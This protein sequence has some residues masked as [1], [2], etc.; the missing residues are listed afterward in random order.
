MVAEADR[1]V[2]S[3]EETRGVE[4]GYRL[5]EIYRETGIDING[6]G[7]LPVI[8]KLPKQRRCT[9]WIWLSRGS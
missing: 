9:R 6:R 5:L 4:T 8:L 3:T 2:K 1:T 7:L